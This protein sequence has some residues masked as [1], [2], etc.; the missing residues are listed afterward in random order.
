[1]E[2][3]EVGED[4]AASWR[5]R[6]PATAIFA[7]IVFAFFIAVLGVL[8]IERSY[9][10][11]RGIDLVAQTPTSIIFWVVL[12]LVVI[13]VALPVSIFALLSQKIALL[14][15]STFKQYCGCGK[16]DGFIEKG[17]SLLKQ[18]PQESDDI[19]DY[20][21]AEIL[22]LI[23]WVNGGT[24]VRLQLTRQGKDFL[25]WCY[26]NGKTRSSKEFDS[27]YKF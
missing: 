5:K 23:S 25:R 6:N 10:I 14:N 17:E 13:V 26:L 22:G 19:P 24:S 2:I 18:L 15:G 12:V 11:E 20:G 8:G 7:P 21:A 1:M 3:R 16:I 4:N 9:W 27:Q